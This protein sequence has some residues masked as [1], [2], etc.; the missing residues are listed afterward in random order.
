MFQQWLAQKKE[1][2]IDKK[3]ATP[4]QRKKKKTVP[5]LQLSEEEMQRRELQDRA[6]KQWLDEKEEQTKD[7]RKME[8]I[9]LAEEA[10][11]YVVRDRKQ[12]DKA[13][14]E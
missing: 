14:R 4:Q 2:K 5:S 10:Q 7:E 12:C 9:R 13:F 8:E 11:N 1:T 6:F 3:P